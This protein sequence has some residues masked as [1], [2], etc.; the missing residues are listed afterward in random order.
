MRR[1]LAD[2]G[3]TKTD[4]VVISRNTSPAVDPVTYSGR[5]LN[6]HILSREDIENEM[7]TVAS[8]LGWNFDEIRFY[9]A[10]VGN[11]QMVGII[12]DCLAKV[13]ECRDIVADSDMAGAARAVLGSCS[14][15]AC[16]MGTG[17]NSC[18]YNGSVIDRKSVSLGY[19]LDDCGGGVAFG[20]RLLSDVFKGIAPDVV[21]EEFFSCYRLTP[22]QVLDRL[23]SQPGANKWIAGFMPFIVS[24]ISDPYISAM[25]GD[26]L[27][28]FLEREFYCYPK[29]QL[30]EEG[31]GFV[32]S[33]AFLLGDHL[34]YA[35]ARRGWMLRDIVCRPLDRL[36]TDNYN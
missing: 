21:A 9:G 4:W 18:H 30:Q 2:S 5:G 20:R 33:V 13:F 29:W 23:Y 35:L 17:S 32:G 24:H 27:D 25:V 7:D 10:G 16:I 14:G 6:P 19:I 34:R 3:S 28:T 8:H 36:M 12:R 1:L 22:P 15:I 31:I 26:V 11:Q